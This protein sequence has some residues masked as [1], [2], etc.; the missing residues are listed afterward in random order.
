MINYFFSDTDMNV[1]IRTGIVDPE[2]SKCFALNLR[3]GDLRNDVFSDERIKF[4]NSERLTDELNQTFIEFTLSR[5]ELINEICIWYSDKDVDTLLGFYFLCSYFSDDTK[6]FVQRFPSEQFD[7]YK[8]WGEVV[9]D[10]FYSTKGKLLTQEEKTVAANKWKEI[11]SQEGSF[12]IVNEGEIQNV[13][14]DYYDESLLRFLLKYP[15]APDA[16]I[17]GMAMFYINNPIDDDWLYYRLGKI[18]TSLSQ[19]D[20]DCVL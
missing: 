5:F 4:I 15:E 8:S 9:A 13:T 7:E 20:R 10:I 6:I 2:K 3:Y 18:K 1:A 16:Q 12:R 11:S 14:E 17:V 19:C